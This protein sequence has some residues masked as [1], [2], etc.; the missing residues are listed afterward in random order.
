MKIL[1]V[2][3]SAG[4]GHQK[5]AEALAHG[6]KQSKDHDVLCLDA[7]DF[8]S[9]FY[10]NIYRQT[11]T[12]LIAHVPWLWG[13]FFGLCDVPFLVPLVRLW[14]R[15][16]NS[17]NAGY[18]HEYLKKE[19]FDYIFSTHFFPT[20]V[21]AALKKRKEISAQVIT[22]V[23]DFDVHSIWIA[24]GV[25]KY[26][27]ASDWTKRKLEGFGVPGDKIFVTGIPIH[28][29][30]SF[31]RVQREVRTKLGLDQQLFT[32]LVATGSFGIG[33]I[34]EIID[35]LPGAQVL[36]VCGHNKKLYE[37]L[38]QKAQKNVKVY[39]LVHNMDEL[40]AASDVMVTK[41]GG[42]SICEALA[43]HLPLIFFNAIPGQ[44]TNNIR[45]LD[46]YGIGFKTQNV[47]M[48]KEVVERLK[49]SPPALAAAV[50]ATKLLAKPHAAKDIAGLIR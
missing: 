50:D 18:F 8:T 6:L 33:P 25:D 40:M 16:L 36:V 11:Y 35:N 37:R 31:P 13:A 3:A 20:E 4:A 46:Q 47:A 7:L 23:T 27:V 34:E 29:K 1:I 49:A 17:I 28:E 19:K 9:P 41:P 22:V 32:V 45:V 42:L 21:A 39:P 26:T 15:F 12:K 48:V 24:D 2:H 43:N 30:F 38:S 5:A 14:R 44:E 10:K